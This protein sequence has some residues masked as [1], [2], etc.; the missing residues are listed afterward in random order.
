[1]N[2]IKNIFC[3]VLFLILISV[4]ICW[5][6]YNGTSDY[7]SIMSKTGHVE[8]LSIMGHDLFYAE[9]IVF[10]ILMPFVAFVLVVI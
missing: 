3:A 5:F 4:S 1:M 2:I 8:W 7:S 9:S 10:D 6:V